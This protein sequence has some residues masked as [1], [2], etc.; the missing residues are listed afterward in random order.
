MSDSSLESIV[1][2]GENLYLQTFKIELEKDHMGEYVAI[3]TDVKKYVVRPSR[4]EAIE[5]AKKEF[6]EKLFYTVQVGGLDKPTVN[7]R[8]HLH[9]W[10]F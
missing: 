6:G 3:D 9:A 8:T 10:N 1:R 7:Y 4:L 5:A 2:E